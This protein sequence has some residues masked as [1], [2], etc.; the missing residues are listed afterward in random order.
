MERLNSDKKLIWFERKCLCR[1]CLCFYHNY[2][3]HSR[4]LDSRLVFH[5]FGYDEDSLVITED[6]FLEFLRV[7]SQDKWRIPL[8]LRTT[9][10]ESMLLFLG[11]N[12]RDL[13]FRI[14]FKGVVDQLKDIRRERVAILQVPPDLSRKERLE[15]KREIETFLAKDLSS[16]KIQVLWT[17]I[18]DFLNELYRQGQLQGGF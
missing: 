5:M 2:Y 4:T 17:S 6:D 10:T 3:K 13:D 15:E 16:L 7:V 1:A 12:I 8:G 18:E 14:F 11:F 9:L